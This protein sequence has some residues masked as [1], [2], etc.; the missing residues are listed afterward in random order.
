MRASTDSAIQDRYQPDPGLVDEFINHGGTLREHWTHTGAAIAGLGLDELYRRQQDVRRLLD[1]DGVTYRILDEGRSEPWKL[2]AVPLLLP[3]SEWASIESGVVQRAVLLDLILRDLYGERKLLTRGVIPAELVLRSPGFLPEHN[4]VA[5]P[6]GGQLFTYALDLGRD[7]EGEFRVAA[8]YAQAPAGAGYALENR[9]VMSRVFPS[10]YRAAQVHR[11]APFFRALRAGL[12]ALAEHRS[13]YPRIVVLTPGPYSE[14][15][16]EHAYLASYLGYSLVEGN[17]LVVRD[18][19]VF[20]RALEGLEPVDVILRRV[21]AAYSDPLELRPDS[22]LGVPGLLEACRRGTVAVVNTLG[23]GVIETPALNAYLPAAASALLGQEL[24]L[25]GLASWW[26]GEPDGL[27][28]VLDHF[29]ELIIKPIDQATGPGTL[30]PQSMS[31]AERD[32]LRAKIIADPGAW[33]GSE[34]LALSTSPTL[35]PDGLQPRRTLLRTY[36]V[37]A[38]GS[39]RVMSGG[40]TRVAPDESS[41][42]ITNQRGAIAK[43]TWVLSTEPEQ[44]SLLWMRDGPMTAGEVFGGLSERGAE[45]LFW[46]GRYLERTDSMVRLLRVIHDRRSDQTL[47]DEADRRAV[48][49]L[50]A[51]LTRT[52]AQPSDQDPEDRGESGID[53]R[54]FLLASDA[55]RPGTLAYGVARLLSAAG[56][57]RDQLSIDTWQVTSTLERALLELSLASPGRQDVVQDKLGSVMQSLLALHGLAA[58]S[59]VRDVG[60]YFMDAGRRIERFQSLGSLLQASLAES[61]DTATDSIVLESVLVAAESI[62]TYRRRYRSRAQV[63]TVLDLLMNDS[64]NPRSMLFQVNRLDE[65]LAALPA[66]E[67]RAGSEALND[68]RR[69]ILRLSTQLRLADTG[70]LSTALLDGSRPALNAFIVEALSLMAA[71]SDS[72]AEANFGTQPPPRNLMAIEQFTA[73]DLPS[74]SQT[75]VQSQSQTQSQSQNQSQTQSQSQGPAGGDADPVAERT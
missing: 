17:D 27:A 10:L 14:T 50:L 42:L 70:E 24:Q 45:N 37:A 31:Q 59:M 25:A 68:A 40:L 72:V 43:D 74:P 21:D 9:V 41:T 44:P 7:A 62:V 8:D 51:A 47:A 64:G 63:Q 12:E 55:E 46:M 22:R 3:S 32:E 71:I 58:E 28:Y 35:T 56:A 65:A 54:L 57:V 48:E 20:L 26:C 1:A 16:F 52:V 19:E 13:S 11:V 29:D 6:A 33:A 49:V 23:S 4:G 69:S 30:A 73:S 61:R 67:G 38:E 15:A 66:G 53:R 5:L 34:M 39:Y 2:D 60:W 36:A 75:S 18:G